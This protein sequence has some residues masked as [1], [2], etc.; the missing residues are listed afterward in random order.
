MAINLPEKDE[1]IGRFNYMLS[2]ITY[3]YDIYSLMLGICI[4]IDI[5]LISHLTDQLLVSIIE[6]T[7]YFA[8]TDDFVIKF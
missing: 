8:K 7:A 5:W 3:C 1:F 2:Y 6:Y 4:Q